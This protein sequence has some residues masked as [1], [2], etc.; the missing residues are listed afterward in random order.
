MVIEAVTVWA[1]KTVTETVVGVGIGT[2][3]TGV[4]IVS[5]ETLEVGI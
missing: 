2:V 5:V 3:G 1:A 4:V